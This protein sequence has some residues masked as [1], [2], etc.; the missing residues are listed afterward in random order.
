MSN[1][2]DQAKSELVI[3]EVSKDDDVKI[4]NENLQG[5][6]GK[7]ESELKSKSDV[8]SYSIICSICKMEPSMHNYKYL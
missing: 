1:E 5:K 6:I 4:A 2:L 8:V 7:L 3:Q